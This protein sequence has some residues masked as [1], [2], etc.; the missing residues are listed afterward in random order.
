MKGIKLFSLIKSIY[1]DKNLL[2]QMINTQSTYSD[3]LVFKKI[4]DEIKD[5]AN[6]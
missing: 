5:L 2:N 6:D 3:K 1:K 4:K